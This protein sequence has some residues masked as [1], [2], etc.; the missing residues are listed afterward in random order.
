MYNTIE[1]SNQTEIK[2]IFMKE[3]DPKFAI[4]RYKRA[5][6]LCIIPIAIVCIVLYVLL[7]Q[8][9]FLVIVLPLYL[10]TLLLVRMRLTR[11]YIDGE[12]FDKLDAESYRATIFN[13]DFFLDPV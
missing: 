3:F 9:W 13:C 11:K 5:A 7:G 8:A 10:V 1:T 4:K 12:L 6:R 2:V